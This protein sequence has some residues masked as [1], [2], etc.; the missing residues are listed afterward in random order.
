MMFFTDAQIFMF[1]LMDAIGIGDRDYKAPHAPRGTPKRRPRRYSS[2]LT[3]R[4]FKGYR[5]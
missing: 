4:L 1:N 2:I 5:P 3:P